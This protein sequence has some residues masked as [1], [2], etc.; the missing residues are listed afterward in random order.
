MTSGE[1]KKKK[2]FYLKYIGKY[3][4]GK[5]IRPVNVYCSV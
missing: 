4:L 2:L 5:D 1:L 3:L